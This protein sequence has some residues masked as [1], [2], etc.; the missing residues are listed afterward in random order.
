MSSQTEERNILI[1]IDSFCYQ[2]PKKT[3]FISRYG[4]ILP[5]HDDSGDDCLG[6]IKLTSESRN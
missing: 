6:I 4:L 2:P 3:V 1:W 5:V